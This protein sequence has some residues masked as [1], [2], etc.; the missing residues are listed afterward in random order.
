[1]VWEEKKIEVHP[2]ISIESQDTTN[3]QNHLEKVTKLK[4]LPILNSKLTTSLLSQSSMLLY[5]NGELRS[6]P[7]QVWLIGVWQGAKTIWWGKDSHFNK[8]LG[9]LD[10]SNAKK[11][12]LHAYTTFKNQLTQN[13]LKT[14]NTK[15]KL[16]DI[17]FGNDFL[18]Y[19]KHKTTKKIV[20]LDSNI[21]KFFQLCIKGHNKQWKYN[22][23]Y[24]RKCL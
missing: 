4:I 14:E 23:Q 20:K 12:R 7:S 21:L 18:I 3:S 5:T 1:M 8:V 24:E 13:G 6:Y 2:K 22:P 11:I 17:G 10:T 9:K 16:Y 15:G 19:Q